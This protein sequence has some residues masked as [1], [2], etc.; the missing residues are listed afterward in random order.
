[1]KNIIIIST[2]TLIEGNSAGSSR[3][4]KY[5]K[6]LSQNSRVLLVS[7][8]DCN[9]LD[10][11]LISKEKNIYTVN[12]QN[13]RNIFLVINYF[14]FFKRLKKRL[15]IDGFFNNSVFLL[16]PS[17]RTL[18]DFFALVFIKLIYRKKIFYEVNELR[19]S[20][21]LNRSFSRIIYKKFFDYCKFIFDLIL[22]I[23]I[24]FMTHF[25]DG[26]IVISTSL[27]KY[28]KPFNSNILR[29]PILSD[30]SENKYQQNSDNIYNTSFK[31]GFFGTISLKKE[32]L[33][34]LYKCIS[35]LVN[36]NI[37][38]ELHL[39]GNVNIN[40]K[41]LLLKKMPFKYG[42]SE[43]IKYNGNIE[44]K[45]IFNEYRKMNLLI[46]PR[47]L[48]LQT[49]YG[50]STKLAEYL[51]SG[52]PVLVTN[53]SDNAIYIKDQIN[54]F[55]IE[56]GNSTVMKN[57]ILS[58]LKEDNEKIKLIV[59]NAYETAAVNFNCLSYSKILNDFLNL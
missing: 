45:N 43:I 1:M 47:P 46:L 42:L 9:S 50:F 34:V 53:V 20:C 56:P 33:N 24:E 44:Q 11:Q 10:Q 27:E 13:F 57:K 35:E 19:R 7:V 16:Y 40:E 21:L 30:L 37:K 6:A 36:D 8:E 3:I 29:I 48:N 14:V 15:K 49:K 17:T 58:I 59:S 5:T 12:K 4:A 28:F 55:I 32:G 22:Y 23:A 52:V 25:F 51:V 2:I 18:F 31:I 54:G 26:L 39:Y 41:E 38:I